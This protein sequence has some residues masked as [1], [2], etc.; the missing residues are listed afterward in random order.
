MIVVDAGFGGDTPV[1]RTQI[2][3]AVDSLR[4][5]P[6]IREVAAFDGP[7]LRS[8]TR[9]DISWRPPRGASRGCLG[10]PKSGVSGA[11]FEVMGITAIA[12]RLP[13]PTE[14]DGGQPVAVVSA[15]TAKLCWPGQSNVIGQTLEIASA[16]FTVVG[17]VPDVRYQTFDAEGRGEL[18]V[19]N[20]LMPPFTT[21]FALRTAGPPGPRLAG[22]I[23]TL[24]TTNLLPRVQRVATMTEA[25]AETIRARRLN[26]W[27]FGVFASAALLIVAVGI[28]GLMAMTTA[29]RTREFGIR[30][31]L[32]GR[33]PA[34]VGLLL[35]EQALAVAIGV[36]AGGVIAT[37][38]VEGTKAYLYRFTPADPRLW[39]I[40]IVHDRRHGARRC[41]DSG[42]ARQPR[43]SD[44]GTESRVGASGTT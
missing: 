33:R 41:A 30:Y 10:G 36:I 31:A 26:A 22:V 4:R 28:L 3:A 29:R 24:R 11:F 13:A 21:V 25:L 1:R 2:A 7:F 44:A 6:G 19:S 39:A 23:E 9:A 40:A 37:W 20:Q 12:G 27:L 16:A 18:Y 5:A 34:I 43:R 14:L 38:A 15:T 42:A 8:S 35:R 32:G 17:V